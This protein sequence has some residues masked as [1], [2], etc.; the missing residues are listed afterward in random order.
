M[1]ETFEDNRTPEAKEER[2]RELLRQGKGLEAIR[3]ALR[4]E[5][6]FGDQDI[7]DAMQAIIDAQDRAEAAGDEDEFNRL[8]AEY[9]KIEKWRLEGTPGSIFEE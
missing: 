8:Q 9:D 3:Y 5:L 6:L 2:R 4:E 7:Y 1:P